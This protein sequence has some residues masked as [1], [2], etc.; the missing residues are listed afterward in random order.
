M[1]EKEYA[2]PRVKVKHFPIRIFVVTFFVL[3]FLTTTQNKILGAYI[4]VASIPKGYIFGMTAYWLLVSAAFTI[5]IRW[6]IVRHY[7]KPL[8]QFVKATKDVA[9]GD[10][11]V[12]VRPIHTA[13]KADYLDVMIA[14]FNKMVAELGSIETLKTDFLS[15]VSH[16]IKTPLA[17]IQN[18]AELLGKSNLSKEKVQEYADNILQ[19]SRRLSQLITDILKL[20]KLEKQTIHPAASE[21]DLCSQ[22]C[23][24]VLHFETLWDQKEIE[25]SAEMEDEAI[26][27][28]DENLMELVWNNLISNAIKF[29]KPGG[30]VTLKQSSTEK[31]IIVQISDNGCGM[32]EETLNHIFDKFYQGD[33]SHAT[34]G[35]GLGLAIAL[36]VLQLM[37]YTI[38]AESVMGQGTTFTVRIPI[39]EAGE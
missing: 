28:A 11:S 2:D 12:Y 19:S 18:Y 25:F 33:T 39:T 34:E 21:Y 14:D 37:E 13:D 30:T 1:S 36:R 15:N 10:F 35:N 5:L 22:L 9:N 26:I 29:T 16:E 24:C 6:Q 7:D 31:E 8:K 4:D 20:S 32:S 3:A 23:E 17:V 27:L 38:L